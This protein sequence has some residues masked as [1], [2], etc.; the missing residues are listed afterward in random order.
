MI[1]PIDTQKQQKYSKALEWLV[2]GTLNVG[3]GRTFL[4]AQAF[5]NIAVKHPG[6]SITIF[7]HIPTLRCTIDIM[8]PE[9]RK[10]AKELYPSGIFTL[11]KMSIKFE[12]YET[13]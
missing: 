4:L 9:I 10:A 6:R 7:D 13:E 5:V 1:V 11:K 8:M 2:S 3:E 12:G